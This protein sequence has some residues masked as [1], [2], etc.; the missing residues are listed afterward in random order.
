MVAEAYGFNTNR[1]I[2][3]SMVCL[4]PHPSGARASHTSNRP[5]NRRAFCGRCS[6]GE[7]LQCRW[8]LPFS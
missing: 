1:A 4:S 5:C 6:G 8:L 2:M 7:A 3:E